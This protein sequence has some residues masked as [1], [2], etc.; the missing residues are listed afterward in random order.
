MIANV[1]V[2]QSESESLSESN[3]K[4]SAHAHGEYGWV[5]LTDTQYERLLTE[6]GKDELERCIR[7]VDESAQSTGNKNKWKD[8]NL[9][10]RK[11]HRDGWGLKTQNV[12]PSQVQASCKDYRPLPDIQELDRLLAKV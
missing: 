3:P 4:E 2:I 7:Y 6:L 11:C 10:V 1:P 12:K 8:W 5:K 9:T